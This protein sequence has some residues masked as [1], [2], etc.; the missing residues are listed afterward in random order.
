MFI[1]KSMT[2][3]ISDAFYDKTID[4]LSKEIN[5]D[6]EGGVTLDAKITLLA[7]DDTPPALITDDSGYALLESNNVIGAFRGNVSFSSCKKLQEEYGLDYDIDIAITTFANVEIAINDLI[8]YKGVV[9]NISDK[10]VS[11]S[12][13]LI[14]AKK[15]Q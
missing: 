7:T 12:H 1:P 13:A 11:D 6:A 14:V 10:L 4:I 15:W 5:V 8:Q 9:Y 3:V 2:K